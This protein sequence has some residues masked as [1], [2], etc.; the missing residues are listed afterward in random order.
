MDIM[1]RG[2]FARPGTSLD[3][4]T[5]T[6]RDEKPLH[7]HWAAPCHVDCPAG[8]DA[9]AWLAKMQENR[10]R[11]AWEGLVAAN[12]M[13]AITGRVCPHPCEI[14]CNRGLYDKPL[15]I[16]LMELFLVDEAI[17]QGWSYPLPSKLGRDAPKVAVVGAGPAGLSA[18]YHLIR[19]GIRPTVFEALP[20][21]GGLLRSAIPMT[22]LPRDV[23]TEELERILATGI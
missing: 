10:L 2:A 12:P 16:H 11:E 21:A 18:A 4:K 7:K 15:A 22:R 19:R 6:W 14:A 23:M 9:Q 8:E 3:Y 1:T 20:E 5:G 13:P 17:R